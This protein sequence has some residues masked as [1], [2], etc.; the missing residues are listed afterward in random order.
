MRAWWIPA[1]CVLVGLLCGAGHALLADRE[2]AA[3]GQVAVAAPEG[4]G[5]PVAFA[6]AF[7]RMATDDAVLRTAQTDA[8]VPAEDLR[9]RVRAAGSPDAP[10]IEITGTAP[11]PEEAARAANAVARALISRANEARDGTGVELIE[12]AAAAVPTGPATPVPGLSLALGACA[13]AVAGCAAH[14]ARRASPLFPALPGVPGSLPPQPLH[15]TGPAPF[16][17]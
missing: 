7:V 5:D 10:V 14:L 3:R 8:G 2:Y 13:G 11:G 9:R 4:E 16:A 12:L 1:V 6:Q 15:T 17:G